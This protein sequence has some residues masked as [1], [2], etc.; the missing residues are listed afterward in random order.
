MHPRLFKLGVGAITASVL[1]LGG[2]G[3]PVLSQPA[4][5]AGFN[6]TSVK[7]NPA[8]LNITTIPGSASKSIKI[9]Y[10][11]RPV[12]P[13]SATLTPEAGCSTSSFTCNPASTTI[14]GDITPGVKELK[15]KKAWN[16]GISAGSSAGTFTGT[17]DLQLKDVNGL[18]TTAFPI[19]MTCNWN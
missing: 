19:Q 17:W 5:A 7:P 6:I 13:L 1:A 18:T 2:A 3:F 8:V 15:W 9:F 4:W 16:C 12:F 14:T 11:G 10:K